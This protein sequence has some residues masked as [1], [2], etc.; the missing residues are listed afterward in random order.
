[1]RP[2]CEVQ[3][4][5]RL[6]ALA[7]WNLESGREV[8]RELENAGEAAVPILADS[9]AD[10]RTPRIA[11]IVV[12]WILSGAHGDEAGRALARAEGDDDLD[13]ASAAASARARY[14]RGRSAA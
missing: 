1:M 10:P 14:F 7:P 2:A 5:I 4:L 3:T 9:L 8:V 13:V 11:R 12:T 6:L